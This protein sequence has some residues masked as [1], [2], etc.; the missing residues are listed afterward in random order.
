M[1]LAYDAEWQYPA[2]TEQH[3]YQQALKY[4][5]E[6]DRAVYIGFPWAT[7]FD[8]E[9]RGASHLAHL[10]DELEHL[11]SK[12]PDGRRVV[13]VCQ[14]IDLRKHLRF[15]VDFGVT[16]VFWSHA[17]GEGEMLPGCGIRAWPFPLYPVQQVEPKSIHERDILFSFVGATSNQ[18]YL[19]QSRAWVGE[20][21]GNHPDGVVVLRDKWHFNKVVYDHQI[22]AKTDGK[23][24]PLTN[25]A[26]TEEYKDILARSQFA[27][28]PSGTGPNSI[29]LWE[30][31]HAGIIPVI[32]ADSYIPPGNPELWTEAAAFCEE[33]REAIAALPDRLA[34]LARDPQALAKRLHALAQLRF[35]YGVENFV[36]DLVMLFSNPGPSATL[37]VVWS[38]THAFYSLSDRRIPVFAASQSAE[39]RLYLRSLATSLLIQPDETLRHL[40]RIDDGVLGSALE[41]FFEDLPGEERALY[42]HIFS[43][44]KGGLWAPSSTV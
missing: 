27:L 36:Y 43:A 32:L 4:L 21:L 9:A 16:D 42:Q 8:A 5:P 39:R 38:D 25:E 2:V 40:E 26:A 34:T 6:T 41:R 3:A 31:V 1:I 29:R 10:K 24:E 18:W 12:V 37:D 20:L 28:C 22:H 7:L 13:T 30:C 11:K 14:H 44:L 23:G 35:C 19:T 33:S 15:M 17:T